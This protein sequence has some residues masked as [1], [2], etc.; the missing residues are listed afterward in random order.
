MKYTPLFL[1]VLF[2][3]LGSCNNNNS[4]IAGTGDFS[5]F[6]LSPIEG[7]DAYIAEKRDA[8]GTILENGVIRNNMK[9][10]M[11]VTY[12]TDER[13]SIKSVTNYLK[14]KKN[15]NHFEFS[16]RGQLEAKAGY[17]NDQLHGMSGAYSLGRPSTTTE[18]SYG[19]L[20]G[21]HIE[22]Y[23][24]G[25]IQKLVEFKDNKQ[26]GLFRYYDEEGRITLEY[27][28]RNGEKVSGGIVSP[29]E[30]GE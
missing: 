27:E 15:G 25:K 9:D 19:L 11:W 7:S 30:D 10:G 5:D 14:G 2:L 13:K 23:N 3:F 12:Y 18:Y 20:H 26:H 28:Y 4:Q 6:T 8:G 17:I 22:Y 16:N 1:L 21:Q 24:S 29:P